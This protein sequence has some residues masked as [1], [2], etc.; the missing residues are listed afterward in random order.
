[1]LV[2]RCF[3]EVK[4]RQIAIELPESFVNHK[5]EIIVLTIDDDAPSRR[6]P[7][8]DIAGKMQI[9]GDILESVPESDWDMSA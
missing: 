1:M 5:V 4:N 9:L 2:Q 6:C 3:E 8:P 7:H